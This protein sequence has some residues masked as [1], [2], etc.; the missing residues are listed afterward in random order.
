[1]I[2]KAFV[3]VCNNSLHDGGGCYFIRTKKIV[4]LEFSYKNVYC[5]KLRVL[6][7]KK[8]LTRK[9]KFLNFSHV[10]EMKFSGFVFT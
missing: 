5:I 10:F 6:P 2:C 3:N 9:N 1:M 4:T 7:Q 8:P